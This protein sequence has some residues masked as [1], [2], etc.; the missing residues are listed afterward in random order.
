MRFAVRLLMLL[1]LAAIA[2]PTLAQNGRP[3][4]LDFDLNKLGGFGDGE[5]GGPLGGAADLSDAKLDVRFA[6]KTAA[7]GDEVTLKI[8]IDIPRGA[9]VYA[10]QTEAGGPTE[11]A[12][13][14]PPSLQS[15]EDGFTPDRAPKEKP[16][17]GFFGPTREFEG[18]VTFSR[19]FRVKDTAAGQVTLN[20]SID[21][22]VCDTRCVPYDE[23]FSATLTVAA[24][25]DNDDVDDGDDAMA[26]GS[27]GDEPETAF[28]SSDGAFGE[29]AAAFGE[30]S[31]TTE[32]A[33]EAVPDAA[34]APLSKASRVLAELAARKDAVAQ[35]L[36][37][38]P[39]LIASTL[40]WCL[41]GGIVLN[42]MPCVLPVLTIKAMSLVALSH[43]N[44]DASVADSS[45]DEHAGSHRREARLQAIGYTVG[46]LAVMIGLGIAMISLRLAWG[47]QFQSPAFVAS[48][49]VIVFALSL[50]LLGVYELPIP[51]FVGRAGAATQ[52]EGF[53]GALF[54]G[55]FATVLAT[56][57]IGPGLATVMGLLWRM[58]PWLAMASMLTIGLGLALPFLLI[59]FFPKLVAWLPRPGMW[60]VRFKQISGFVLLGTVIY[61]LTPLAT[62][63]VVPLLI[64]MLGVAFALWTYGEFAG[65]EH[66]AARRM[67]MS[68]LALLLLV[69]GGYAG[70]R[71]APKNPD[72]TIATQRL[73][74][75]SEVAEQITPAQPTKADAA[76]DL[77]AE[78]ARVVSTE[79]PWRPFDEDKLIDLLADRE[80]VLVDFTADWCVNCKANEAIALNTERVRK[81]V[82]AHGIET[83][84][85]DWTTFPP[86]DERD[87]IR[88][89]INAFGRDAIPL[90]V[91]FPKGSVRDAIILDA[92]FTQ[93]TLLDRL[94]RAIAYEPTDVAAAP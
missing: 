30:G 57:C 45:A 48:L 89:W 74:P 6:P 83:M 79:L 19:R 5:F 91:I 66:P 1:L 26:F 94:E 13:E 17:K 18:S 28:G 44:G 36:A 33:P 23:T 46:V 75:R 37:I 47:Q 2:S 8:T 60:M 22:Q 87:V 72:G 88:E 12:V 64:A 54:S 76:I 4:A 86:A 93:S 80:T 70:Y 78:A 59:G 7:P 39:T 53:G 15:L 3:S 56:P 10:Q 42:V 51:G 20:G 90:T 58:P 71:F 85:A 34:A 63:L 52:K 38:T 81:L 43:G 40:F 73:A 62:Q 25:S 68:V 92:A 67:A 69:G 61:L 21:F 41:V 82:E 27:S 31:E 14:L 65:P 49:A 11:I 50:S 84:I 24:A 9:H 16:G 77:Q 29:D 32:A 55:V 35:P